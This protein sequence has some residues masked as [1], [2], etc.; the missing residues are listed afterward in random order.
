MKAV[1]QRVISASLSIDGKKHSEIGAGLVV[2]LG[3]TTSDQLE[4]I[5]WMTRK[6]SN[7]RIFSDQDGLMNLSL[8]DIGGS[9]LVVSQ[10]T[11]MA[12]SKKGNRPSFIE[13]APPKTAIPIYESFVR[14]LEKQTQLQVQTGVFG[15][16]MQVQL[17]NDGPVTIILDTKL[18]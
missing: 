8:K 11:L 2:L 12:N 16:N 17:I 1:V 5:H 9:T 3:I 15:A 13:A 6:I 7:L 18:K 4:D 14:E 10:F